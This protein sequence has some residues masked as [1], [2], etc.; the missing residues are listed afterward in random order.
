MLGDVKESRSCAEEVAAEI[1]GFT[2]SQPGIVEE[3][4]EFLASAEFLL[5][6]G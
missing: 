6:G 1:L 5:L 3:R 4:V 2:E